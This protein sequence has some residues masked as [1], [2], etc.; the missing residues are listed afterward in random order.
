MDVSRE[1]PDVTTKPK[2][3][4]LPSIRACSQRWH[5]WIWLLAQATAGSKRALP[6]GCGS[7]VQ[8]EHGRRPCR[9]Q[10]TR[11]VQSV[12]LDDRLEDSAARQTRSATGACK[13]NARQERRRKPC[14]CPS[15]S[16]EL[17]QGCRRAASHHEIGRVFGMSL[18][19]SSDRVG[20]KMERK[21]GGADA[22]RGPRE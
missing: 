14:T 17:E 11:R 2:C 13:R 12:R 6:H 22:K 18:H 19:S 9:V 16:L 21:R 1:T 10:S 5:V 20:S 15:T 4:D 3:C 8:P 7:F